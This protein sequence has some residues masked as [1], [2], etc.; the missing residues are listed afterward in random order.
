MP[1][2]LAVLLSSIGYA[3]LGSI[4]LWIGYRLFDRLTPGDAHAKI[5][6]EGNRAVALLAGAFVIGL[7]VIIAA[8]IVG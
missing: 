1:H 7:S 3:V 4:L 2:A 6:E 5:F 8:A